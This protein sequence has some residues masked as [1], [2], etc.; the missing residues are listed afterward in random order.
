MTACGCC[1]GCWGPSGRDMALTA[2]PPPRSRSWPCGRWRCS[3]WSPRGG[4]NRQIA[5]PVHLAEGAVKDH[6]TTVLPKLDAR[7][8]TNAVLRARIEGILG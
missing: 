8:R 6:I 1:V 2:R 7:D 5:E 4:A 3:D